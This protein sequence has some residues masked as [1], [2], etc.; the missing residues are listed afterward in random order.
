M[1]RAL[2]GTGEPPTKYGLLRDVEVAETGTVAGAVAGTAG[3]AAA[4]APPPALSAGMEQ[5]NMPNVSASTTKD[6]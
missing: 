5:I 4:G 6:G 1:Q 3:A 2:I